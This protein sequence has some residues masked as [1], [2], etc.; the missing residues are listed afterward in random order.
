M[1]EAGLDGARLVLAALGAVAMA[2]FS[3]AAATARLPLQIALCTF[4]AAIAA[5]MCAAALGVASIALALVAGAGATFAVAAS[6]IVLPAAPAMQR[7]RRMGS[8]AGAALIAAALAWAAQDVAPTSGPPQS[9]AQ[10]AAPAA[11]ALL[12]AAIGAYALM[13][14]GERA[15]FAQHRG[16]D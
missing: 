14:F 3:V 1:I 10:A 5:A 15:V 12:A 9:L 7:A 2:A 8:R 4:F 13:G 6:L 16:D 11:L